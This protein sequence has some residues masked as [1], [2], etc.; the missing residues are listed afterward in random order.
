[1]AATRFLAVE[2]TPLASKTHWG[3]KSSLFSIKPWWEWYRGFLSP[4]FFSPAT[5]E[6]S[7]RGE[8]RLRL[9]WVEEEEAISLT[10]LREWEKTLEGRKEYL[11]LEIEY[12]LPDFPPTCTI[13]RHPIWLMGPSALQLRFAKPFLASVYGQNMRRGFGNYLTGPTRQGNRE[14]VLD[15]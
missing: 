12:I 6:G 4:T 13:G 3:E 5:V 11:S 15:Q 14:R 10:T 9:F 7:R 8:K 1:M 2:D